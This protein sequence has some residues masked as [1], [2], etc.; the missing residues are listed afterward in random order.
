MRVYSVYHK[1]LK[2]KP[3]LH[4]FNCQHPDI[5]NTLCH[6]MLG[7]CNPVLGKEVLP[8]CCH[9]YQFGYKV[10]YTDCLDYIYVRKAWHQKILM[11]MMFPS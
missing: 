11:L 9:L 7:P 2:T 1:I 4:L 8:D 5:M 6:F 10:V 3:L